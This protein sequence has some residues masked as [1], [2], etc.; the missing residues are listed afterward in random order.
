M[1]K[2]IALLIIIQLCNIAFAQQKKDSLMRVELPLLAFNDKFL[3][4]SIDSIIF[5][6][7]D[8]FT[9]HNIDQIFVLIFEKT[10]P[11]KYNI[12]LGLVPRFIALSQPE[13]IGYIGIRNTPCILRGKI[14]YLEKECW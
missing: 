1:K 3:I 13:N 11:E 6:D 2:T 7:N 10:H 8:C 12:E 4:N 9:E 14:T 5:S